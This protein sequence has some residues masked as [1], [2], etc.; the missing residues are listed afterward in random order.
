[1]VALSSCLART[2]EN[3]KKLTSAIRLFQCKQL[4][5][6]LPHDD[7]HHTAAKAAS[8]TRGLQM[9]LASHIITSTMASPSTC[10]SPSER[11]CWDGFRPKR[12]M[13]AEAPHSKWSSWKVTLVVPR[14]F[15]DSLDSSRKAFTAMDCCGTG[16]GGNSGIQSS[17]VVVLM[18]LRW[19]PLSSGDKLA[20]DLRSLAVVSPDPSFLVLVLRREPLLCCERR[21]A[22]SSI[23]RAVLRR[24]ATIRSKR[25]GR[26]CTSPRKASKVPT[27]L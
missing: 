22:P 4:M 5:G 1:M 25:E 20:V 9:S 6:H 2:A 17:V 3:M 7:V 21:F 27:H 19:I 18:E 14:G 10:A 11:P 26:W 16:G 24:K 8:W 15:R 13:G 23:Q 12:S